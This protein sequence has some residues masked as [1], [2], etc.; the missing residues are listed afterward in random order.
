MLSQNGWTAGTPEQIGGLDTS[1]VA[2]VTF[3]QG[4]RRG[5]VAV[6]LHY[7]ALRFHQ[8]VEHLVPGW[9]WGYN[10]RPIEGSTELSNHSA[11]CAVDLNAPR[12]AMSKRGTFAAAQVA[13][14]HRILDDCDGVLRWGGDY[15]GRADEMHVEI[16]GSAA[17]VAKLA[18]KITGQP[19]PTPPSKTGRPAPGPEISYPLPRR[20]YFGPESGGDQSVSGWHGRMFAGH[21]DRYW[22]QT[23]AN[24]LR[25]RGWAIGK[26]RR[27]LHDA[28]NDGKFGAEYDALV[29]AFQR[30]QA[31]PVDGELGPRTWAA[32]WRNP[33]R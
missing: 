7:F 25:R 29:R 1:P 30:D 9:C 20:Y 8:E 16:V 24:Q 28:G 3:P 23:F 33:I 13:A 27:Y 10:Y 11:G 2:G 17:A 5:P 12:H 14:I 32:A 6:V 19:A 4:V 26:G 15:T 21:T 22:L 18:A 31:L